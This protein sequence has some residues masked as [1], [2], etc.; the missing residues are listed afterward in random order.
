MQ[1]LFSK[2]MWSI[3]TGIFAV[4]TTASIVLA[5]LANA[6]STAVNMAL[7][8]S[9]IVTINDP[10]AVATDFYTTDYE[11]ERN[12]ENMYAEDAAA[13]E[14]AEAEGAVLL[15]NKSAALPLAGTESVSLLGKSS[16]DLVECGS[17]SG[18]TRTYD[19][20]L[21]REVRTTMKDAFE[22]RGFNVNGT[23]WNFYSTGAGSSDK[24]NRTSP[25]ELCTPWQ[26]WYVNEVPWSVYTDEVKRSFSQ[27]GDAAIVV[28][29]RSGGEYS[30]LHYNYANTNDA[31]GAN[32]AGSAENTSAEGG[33]LGLTDE[34]EELLKNVT[35]GTFGKVIVLLNTGNPIQMQ[36]LEKYY[37]GIDAC[38]WIGQPGSTG[39]N[40]VA[41]LIKGKDMQGNDLSPSGR[42]TDT[43]VYDNNSAPATVNDGNYTYA[44][45]DL[46]NTKLKADIGY[47]SKYMVY[48]E[49]I[50][51]GYRYYETRYA[52][53][54]AGKGNADSEKG[55]KHSKG[56]WNYDEEV[57]FPFGYGLSYTEFTYSGFEV[58]Y[59]DGEYTVSVNVTNTGDAS[60]KEVVMVYLSKP[61]TEYDIQTGI[62]KSAIELAGY[63]KTRTLA[64]GEEQ[65]VTVAVPEEYFKTYDANGEQTYIIEEG[66]YFLT[67]AS[68]AH[69][70]VNNILE[71]GG[72]EVSQSVMGGVENTKEVSFGKDF[73]YAVE[74]EED[75]WTYARSSQT[76]E[77][78][79][80]RFDS[81]DINKYDGKGNNSVTWLSRSDWDKT[82]PQGPAKLSLNT[83]MASDLDYDRLPADDGY[84]MPVYGVFESGSPD[85]PDVKNGD[86]VAYQFMDAP[87]YPE[88]ASDPDE[89]YN[90]ED[91]LTY[92]D[93]E[94]RWNQL[95]DQMTFEEQVYIVVNSYHWIQGA[96]SIALPASRQENG[97]VGITK[98]EEIFFSLPN[99]ETLRETG[100]VWVSYPCAGIIAASFNN[101]IAQNIGEHKSEDMLYLGY[102]GIY[103]PGVNLHRSPYGGRAFEYPSEDPFL[104]GMIEAYECIGIESKGCLAYAKHFAL[105]DME[106]NRVNC[107]I[108]A[109]EQTVREIYLRAFEIVFTE[110]KASATMNAY[111]RMGTTWS[112]ASY[113]M[114]TEVLRGEWGWDGLVISDWDTKGS[115][116]S[117]LDGVLAGTDTFD[118]NNAVEVLTVYSDN[119]AV[120]QAVRQ[121]AKRVIY[122]VV[123]TNAMNGM[124]I[125]SRTVKVTPWWQ[126][127]LLTLECTFGALTAAAVG[128]FVASVVID[129]RRK[130]NA[131]TLVVPGEDDL[132]PEE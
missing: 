9:T 85:A 24:Y 35:D 13:I 20:K 50:Y 111:T 89:V 60:G 130:S 109:N 106:T 53:L 127:L 66:T 54:V 12:G 34:E 122:N 91:G 62:E 113:E 22:S 67:V 64:P 71:H 37:D 17:G 118:G 15:W 80:N 107:G 90:E 25:E 72:Y 132:P 38:M 40:A 75:F 112:G 115:A 94:A 56:G 21:G 77:D 63:A 116:M 52:D 57:A 82:Y 95:L 86:L 131:A 19:Y 5:Y 41:D 47:H 76:G 48:Q 129:I 124:T 126:T 59:R 23:L 10:D 65:T 36:D 7:N 79:Y 119:A 114:M 81:A 78:I 101:E 33:Y 104:A 32:D 26:Q 46:L 123:R 121:A 68:D 30:D 103:G 3:I 97:P 84:D 102:N 105:N 74:L 29:S 55:A 49:G 87:L 61:Y 44:N 11:F 99:E 58:S 39:I 100:W 125:S 43:W 51:I 93:W 88:L 14:E 108:W 6:N 128:M 83:Q 8:T 70:A 120:A 18:F 1:K 73:A 31:V 27:Y 96:E 42:L 69:T 117:K 92:R 28:L 2:V 98:R 110:G 45:T 16:V 4:L